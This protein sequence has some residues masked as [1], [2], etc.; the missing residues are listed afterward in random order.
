[1]KSTF[2]R[3]GIKHV[4]CIVLGGGTAGWLTALTMLKYNPT[5]QEIVLVESDKIP[6][7]GAG[8]G[9]TPQILRILNYLDISQKEFLRKTNGTK[10]FGVKFTNWSGNNDV[11]TNY[12][13]N[14]RHESYAYHFD[15]ALCI[16]YLK[17]LAKSRGVTHIVDKYV[18][19]EKEGD[20]LKNITLEK[21][22]K[23]SAQQYFDCSGFA[24]LL[25]GKALN[26]KWISTKK[27]LPVNSAIPFSLA[28]DTEN[29]DAKTYTGAI[30][31]NH[32]WLWTIPLQTRYGCGYVFDNTNVSVEEAQDEIEAYMGKKIFSRWS[33][34]VI[35]FESGYYED[36][37]RGNV[38]SIGL[39]GG[40][41]EPLE[42]TSLMTV[43]IQ[44]EYFLKARTLE[45]INHK[46]YNDFIRSVNRQVLLNLKYHYLNIK[47]DY[48]FWKKQFSS[49]LPPDLYPL[50]NED[51]TFKPKSAG[52]Y[53]KI[54]GLK[55]KQEFLFTLEN[56]K[57]FSNSLISKYNLPVHNKRTF[58]NKLK[59][60][61]NLN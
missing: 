3:D 53:K 47:D 1:M 25:I 39:S 51:F 26:T 29:N 9:T 27:Y 33:S 41:F 13:V 30:A 17:D 19:C 38:F 44:L 34:R 11:F 42:A 22:G 55:T 15:S 60:L 24:R 28:K 16:A 10:K 12:F 7:V 18:G 31:L 40:F 35:N 49:P 56:W 46:K 52:E 21:F 6:G 5:D 36:Q 48:P 45:N 50:M 14:L 4:S 59:S 32:G 23:I 37:Y 58:V 61:L 43:C 8:E 57:V 20:G 54:L 2:K